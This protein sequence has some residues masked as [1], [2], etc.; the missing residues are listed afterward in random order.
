MTVS[1]DILALENAPKAP[2]IWRF[3]LAAFFCVAVGF[4]AV[5]LSVDAIVDE[6]RTATLT[7]L[8]KRLGA[9]LRGKSELIST[10][11]D[12]LS[13]LGNRLIKSDLVR[14]FVTELHLQ[15][16]DTEL[17]EALSAQKPY[18]RQVLD[19]LAREHDLRGAYLLSL[20]GSILLSD[21]DAPVLDQRQKARAQKLV[22]NNSELEV[23]APK[24]LGGRYFL[25]ILQP[26]PA[27]QMLTDSE[28]RFVGVM[29][30]TFDVTDMLLKLVQADP[31]LEKGE[32]SSLYIENHA[33]W[34]RLDEAEAELVSS[35]QPPIQGTAALQGKQASSLS[36]QNGSYF[37]FRP[38]RGWIGKSSDV[39]LNKSSMRQ[40]RA[41][42]PM[43]SPSPSQPVSS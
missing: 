4:G 28:R 36:I 11:I 34:F 37:W 12:G 5:K 25:D 2:K 15:G 35:N 18:M 21:H 23:G 29:M 41:L 13:N 40:S 16:S 22:A 26:V 14:L 10:W 39:S 30:M 43:H 24:L 7:E 42:N 8:D 31:L 3:G 6:R 20:D 19:D 1:G 32:A 17:Q 9:Q 27:A 38:L 33:G